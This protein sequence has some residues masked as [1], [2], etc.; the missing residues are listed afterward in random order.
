MIIRNLIAAIAFAVL[1]AG[2][3]CSAVNDSLYFLFQRSTYLESVT[4]PCAWWANPAILAET[5]RKTALTATVLP[6]GG[7]YTIASVRYCAP[8]YNTFSWGIGLLGAGINRNPDGSLTASNSG[9]QYRSSVSLSNPSLQGG[10]AGKLPGDILAGI[11]FDAGLELLPDGSGGQANFI[12]L[13]MGIGAMTPYIA[14]M[15]SIGLSYMPQIHFWYHSYWDHDGKACLRIKSSDSLIMGSLEYTFSR[16]SGAIK[17]FYNSTSA[18]YQVVKG[19]ASIKTMGILGAL[20]G[21]SQDLGILSDNGP[22]IHLG[23][24]I[25]QSMLYPYF[26]GYEIGIGTTQRHRNLIV[27]RLWVGYCF[28]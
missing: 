6:L 11:L 1:V 2:K 21:F 8:A 28:P 5:D 20:A 16:A 12:T 4:M 18:Y 22:M 26:G 9:A 15:V 24:E 13:G 19:L 25:R 10:V 17:H 7:V 3:P 23:I 14:N 27:H